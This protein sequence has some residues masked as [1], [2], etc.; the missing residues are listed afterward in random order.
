MTVKLEVTKRDGSTAA[1][2][3]KGMVPAVVYGPKQEPL[4]LAID[5]QVFTKVLEAAGESTIISLAGLDAEVEVLIHDVAFDPAR[6]GIEHVDFYAIER[7][8]ELTTHV[9]LEFTGEAPV[10]KQGATI[11]KA[12]HEIEVTCRPSQLPSEIV[13]DLGVLA[14]EDSVIAVKDLVIP[15]GVKVETDAE[16]IVASVAAARAE[17]PEAEAVPA[18]AEAETPAAE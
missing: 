12:L 5:K 15:A 4:S 7:G 1:L 9:A 17:E 18:A 14:D 13:V 3:A 16:L 6:G 2:R 8:K 10:V 11:N